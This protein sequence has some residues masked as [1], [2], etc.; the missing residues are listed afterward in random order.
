MHPKANSIARSFELA[1]GVRVSKDPL[2]MSNAQL[3]DAL[4]DVAGFASA[5]LTEARTLNRI[6][7]DRLE[8]GTDGR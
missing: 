8:R 1:Y 2:D 6:I 3:I 7:S 4:Y 5:R